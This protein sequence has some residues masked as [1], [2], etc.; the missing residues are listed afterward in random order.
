MVEELGG[1][2]Q[3]RQLVRLGAHD[4][5]LTAAVRSGEVI[6]A[7][8]G[9]YTTLDPRS[10]AVQA[11]RVGGRLT[12][13][14]A[15]R[16][17]GGWAY[18]PTR[19]HVSVPMNAARLRSRTNRRRRLDASNPRGVVVHWES[20]DIHA[21]GSATAVGLRD[22][23]IRVIL[24]ESEEAAV[25]ALD[26]AHHSGLLDELDLA[27]VAACIP[28][29]RRHVIAA[30]KKECESF[31]ESLA[32]TRLLAAGHEVR[33]QVPVEGTRER[34]DLVIDARL[35]LEIDGREFHAATFEQDSAKTVRIALQGLVPLRVSASLVLDEWDVVMRAIAQLL[36]NSGVEERRTPASPA[37]PRSRG[38]RVAA[39]PEFPKV[40]RAAG[41]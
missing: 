31:P 33:I 10:P 15:I 8:Q 32:R 11:V 16:A 3:K 14:S 38:R 13:I 34:I 17:L 29:S 30:V 23:L 1:M 37:I 2:A 5:H 21:R 26:W 24:D 25:A 19:L 28:R 35:G 6:R 4:H 18:T 12:G 7:R 27:T 9:W 41:S 36:G 39:G 40:A 22:A 20:E